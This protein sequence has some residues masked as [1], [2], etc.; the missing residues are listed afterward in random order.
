[1]KKRLVRIF[2][3]QITSGDKVSIPEDLPVNVILKS[4]ETYFGRIEKID[5]QSVRLCDGRFHKHT[6]A[7]PEIDQIVYD[8]RDW[9]I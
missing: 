4:G 3:D 7:I 9:K 1:M 2:R 6:I 5:R 8:V